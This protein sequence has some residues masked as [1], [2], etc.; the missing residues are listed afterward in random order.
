MSGRGPRGN[1]PS[2]R[3][4]AGVRRCRRVGS[5]TPHA[6]FAG[7]RSRLRAATRR[8]TSART[9]GR[10][11]APGAGCG[12]RRTSS[13]RCREGSVRTR[14]VTR[15]ATRTVRGLPRTAHKP[16][17]GRSS[18]ERPVSRRGRHDRP[19]TCP[20]CR[21]RTGSSGRPGTTWD[22]PAGRWT[23]RGRPDAAAIHRRSSRR[24]APLVRTRAGSR[25]ATRSIRTRGP[26][27]LG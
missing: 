21:T 27:R 9:E 3:R 18:L 6:G 17:S 25:P 16:A 11:S 22:R 13:R 12:F 24:G 26:A 15:R 14:P 19:R 23:W 7:T 4:R 1:P 10:G 5:P 20:R 8:E 2:H